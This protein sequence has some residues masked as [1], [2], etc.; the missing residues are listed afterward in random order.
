M[1]ALHTKP[2]FLP[3]GIQN[4]QCPYR[5][6]NPLNREIQAL[7]SQNY[8]IILESG[9]DLEW[10]KKIRNSGMLPLLLIAVCPPDGG[11][12]SRLRRFSSLAMALQSYTRVHGKKH[13]NRTEPRNAVAVVPTCAPGRAAMAAL[14][15]RLSFTWYPI[16][17]PSCSF[18]FGILNPGTQNLMF[19]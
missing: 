6:S 3:V 8:D 9:V 12:G 18:L 17:A 10:G 16:A 4:N 19:S 14:F 15:S 13:T 5:F 1:C 2:F 11:F 7:W